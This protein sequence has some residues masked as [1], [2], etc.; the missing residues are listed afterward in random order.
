MSSTEE[1]Q[2]HYES[3]WKNRGEP[4]YWYKGPVNK[5]YPDF[6]ILE[7]KPTE[8]RKMWTYATCCM[9]SPDDKSPIELHIFSLIKNEG[10]IELLTAVAYYHKND[11]SL[12]LNHTFNFGQPWQDNSDCEYGFV[13]LPYMDG[14]SLENGKIAGYNNPVK[15]YWL[16]PITESEVNFKIKFGVD[17]LENEFENKGFD[18]LNPARVSVV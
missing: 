11:S 12:G 5:L 1:I 7:F 17:E 2:L 6:C 4:R 10:L 8:S 16:I 18:Y 9:S 3:I 14:P 15:F 13:S